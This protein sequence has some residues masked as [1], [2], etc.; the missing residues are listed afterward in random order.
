MSAPLILAVPSKGRLQENAADFFARAGLTIKRKGGARNYRGRIAEL[1]NVEIAFLS[2][3]EITNELAEGNVHLGVTGE[4]LVRERIPD[5]NGI[6]ELVTPLG[7]G[8]ADVVIAVPRAWIDVRSMTDLVDVAQGYPGAHGRRLRVATKYSTLTS[9][10]FA[11]H[12]LS[13][14][15]LV[16]S[17]GATEGA[18]EAGSAEI[19]VDITSTGSTLAANDLKVPQG[20]TILASQANL[21]ASLRAPWTAAARQAL[22]HMLDQI[23]AEEK[24]RLINEIRADW[25]VDM[26]IS[27]V[28]N[29]AES[30]S[31]ELIE[32]AGNHAILH[33]PKGEIYQVAALLKSAGAIRTSVFALNY[34]FEQENKLLAD[35]ISKLPPE[36][37]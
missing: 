27:T 9:R 25:N 7:F 24:A 5:S 34:V 15:R 21:V 16:E 17:L 4:D 26:P 23:A 33:V 2:A 22:G 3:S 11:G 14:Y 30:S 18:P 6:V 32:M 1:E 35:V 31:S 29:I 36:L 10:F 37:K 19:I 13:E 12:N 8:H 28:K 20:C